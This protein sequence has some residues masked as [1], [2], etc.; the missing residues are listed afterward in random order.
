MDARRGQRGRC[1]RLH[2]R[3]SGGLRDQAELRDQG[4]RKADTRARRD[5]GPFRQRDFYGSADLFPGSHGAGSIEEEE[6]GDRA[7]DQEE[8]VNK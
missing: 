8:E 2:G 3:G 1:A 7:R 4:L 5:S 6:C